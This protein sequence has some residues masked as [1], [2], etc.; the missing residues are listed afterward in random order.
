MLTGLVLIMT[1]VGHECS[2]QAMSRK[3]LPSTAPS[4][5]RCTLFTPSMVFPEQVRNVNNV[6]VPLQGIQGELEKESAAVVTA[7][8][9]M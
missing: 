6:H 7:K 5:R 3:T 8:Y 2:G 9:I 1:A 4:L